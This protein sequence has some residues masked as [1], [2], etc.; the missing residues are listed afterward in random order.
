MRY[1]K[2]FSLP[3]CLLVV[4]LLLQLHVKSIH[5]EDM[6]GGYEA[7]SLDQFRQGLNLQEVPDEAVQQDSTLISEKE[8]LVQLTPL[9]ASRSV[10]NVASFLKNDAINLPQRLVLLDEIISNMAYGFS[11]EDAI[12]L[13]LD[14]ANNYA[15]GS[16]EQEQLFGVLLKHEDLLKRTSP[17]FIA[18]AN[19]YTHTYM[20]LLAWSIKN[21]ATNPEAK[22]DLL[23][24]KMRALLHAVD[25]GEAQI[26]DKIHKNTAQGIT[27]D[28]ATALVWHIAETATHPELLAK[29]KEYGAD[30]NQAKGKATPLIE[31]VERGYQDV[32][33]AFIEQRVN[34]D[35][36][37]DPEFGTALQRAI[38]QRNVP[39]EELLRRAGARE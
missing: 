35:A 27:Q 11:I 16:A 39:L 7:P 1:L 9:L 23:E 22:K 3:L 15:P 38:A 36:L 20:P 29:L 24:L 37:A 18:I 19:D 17:L 26:L 6:A 4:V 30:M 2:P 28:E 34:L 10:E 32:V 25:S 12:Q 33:A 21:A 5:S 8:L 14:V 31:A 13:I